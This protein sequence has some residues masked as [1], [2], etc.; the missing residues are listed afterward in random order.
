MTNVVETTLEGVEPPKQPQSQ[1]DSRIG[2][3]TRKCTFSCRLEKFYILK[4]SISSN[5]KWLALDEVRHRLKHK[6]SQIKFSWNFHLNISFSPERLFEWVV[7]SWD[8]MRNDGITANQAKPLIQIL[9][10]FCFHLLFTPR[11]ARKNKH[12]NAKFIC[13]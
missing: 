13:A 4:L 3:G 5:S 1:R 6:K 11:A 2:T 9:T 8:P 10:E 12:L 7:R